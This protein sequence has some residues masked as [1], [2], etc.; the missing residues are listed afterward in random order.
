MDAGAAEVSVVIPCLNEART[1]AHCIAQARLGLA[2]LGVPGEIVVA[3][4]GSSDGSAAIAEAHGASVVHVERKG[5]GS[6]LLAGIAAA[7][8]RFIVMGDGDASYDFSQIAPF[9]ERLRA[10][11]DLVLGNR[12]RGGIRPGAMPWS[13]RYIGNPILTGLLNLFFRTTVGDAHCGLRAFRKDAIATL[14][15][16]A[17]GM[18]FASEMIVKASL[19]GLRISEVPTVLHPDGRGRPPHL[20]RFR[21]GWRHLRLLVALR[22]QAFRSRFKRSRL[23]LAKGRAG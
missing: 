13:N 8:G 15:L 16:A 4:N 2:A 7:R 5:Y 9:I 22:V 20:R 14:E 23:D 11:D 1:L 6:A 3:D 19:G 21:D 17:P 10:G 18:E 12:F